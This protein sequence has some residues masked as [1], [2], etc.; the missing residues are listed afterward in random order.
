MAVDSLEL[1]ERLMAAV[2]AGNLDEVRNIYAPDAIIW[3][4]SDNV[5]QSVN[6]NLAVLGWVVK[7]ISNRRYEEILRQRTD[8]GFV[9]QHVFR[10]TAPNGKLIEMRACLICTVKDGRV[11]RLDEYLDSAHLTPLTQ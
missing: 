6:E 3:H 1:G 7:N 10:G 2:M 4:N 5:E 11:T 9:Q 8:T